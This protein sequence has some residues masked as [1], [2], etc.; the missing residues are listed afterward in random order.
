MKKDESAFN[1]VVS[2]DMPEISNSSSNDVP[3]SK[4]PSVNSSVSENGSSENP[5]IADEEKNCYTDEEKE[6]KIL[7]GYNDLRSEDRRFP[8]NYLDELLQ[9]IHN[10]YPSATI[11]HIDMAYFEGMRDLSKIPRYSTRPELKNVLQVLYDDSMHHFI[12]CYYDGNTDAIVI[13]DGL[14]QNRL[15]SAQWNGDSELTNSVA[16]ILGF[17]FGRVF[18]AGIKIRFAKTFTQTDGTNCGPI[19]FALVERIARSWDHGYPTPSLDIPFDLQSLRARMVESLISKRY[20]SPRR[21][22]RNSDGHSEVE[23]F[24]ESK[25][26]VISVTNCCNCAT[27]RFYTQPTVTSQPFQNHLQTFFSKEKSCSNVDCEAKTLFV[28]H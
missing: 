14:K 5:I 16:H 6:A 21:F 22:S 17:L 27:R 15:N 28:L 3:V 2:G 11:K 18:P 26:C 9:G 7:Q 13:L 19:A 24:P 10:A 12:G 1:G 23:L 8:V 4:E 25:S 20:K